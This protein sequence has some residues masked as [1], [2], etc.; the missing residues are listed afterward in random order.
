MV[1]LVI[2]RGSVQDKFELLVKMILNNFDAHVYKKTV[3]W[4]NF[5]LKRAIKFMFYFCVVM[6]HKFMTA[7]TKENVFQDIIFHEDDAF[8]AKE[9][10]KSSKARSKINE[11]MKNKEQWDLME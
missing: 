6:P 10:R 1:A 4:E 7:N 5:Y 11:F 9:R 8:K 2:C 3:Y